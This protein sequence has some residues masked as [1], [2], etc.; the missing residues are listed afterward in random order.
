MRRAWRWKSLSP[1]PAGHGRFRHDSAARAR[2]DGCGLASGTTSSG[3]RG[4]APRGTPVTV[5]V[6]PAP[7]AQPGGCCNRD[8]DRAS[9][10]SVAVARSGSRRA[11]GI[12][13]LE[14]RCDNHGASHSVAIRDPD[15][16]AAA[17]AASPP[18]GRASTG[19][20]PTGS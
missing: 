4:N 20:P 6:A 2:G 17:G 5:T 14:V 3:P 18:A 9:D 11:S 19:P 7:R 15:S 12:A 1:P 13:Q 16:A 8:R 10:G